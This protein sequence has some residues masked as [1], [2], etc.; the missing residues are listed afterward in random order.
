[1][2]LIVWTTPAEI[3]AGVVMSSLMVIDSAQEYTDVAI[4]HTG[5]GN[6]NAAI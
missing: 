5:N 6:K 2:I 3:A 4:A 1:L